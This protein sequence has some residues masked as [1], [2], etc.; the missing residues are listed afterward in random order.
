MTAPIRREVSYSHEGWRGRIRASAGVGG[1]LPDARVA[2]FDRA[3]AALLAAEFPEQPLQVPHR[4][5]A[6]I[7]LA[8]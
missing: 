3:L 8:P 7:A 6:A 1:S 4:A 2:A 5:F